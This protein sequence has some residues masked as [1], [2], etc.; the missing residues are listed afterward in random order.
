MS[1]ADNSDFQYKRYILCL[2]NSANTKKRN[3]L[4]FSQRTGESSVNLPERFPYNQVSTPIPNISEH[5]LCY[6]VWCSMMRLHRFRPPQSQLNS[7]YCDRVTIDYPPPLHR[8]VYL[9]LLL[10][11]RWSIGRHNNGDW[12][13]YRSAPIRKIAV[14]DVHLIT[15]IPM[16]DKTININN[17]KT[18]KIITI[19]L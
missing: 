11:F 2:N 6:D 15:P 19:C 9:V 10:L 8:R 17:N 7:E 14:P 3:H 12:H 5:T 16:V 1:R 18:T 13:R 4:A